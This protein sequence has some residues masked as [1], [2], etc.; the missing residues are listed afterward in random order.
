MDVVKL[1]HVDR[2]IFY[3]KIEHVDVIT[4]LLMNW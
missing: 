3:K 1:Q 2:G 4:Q